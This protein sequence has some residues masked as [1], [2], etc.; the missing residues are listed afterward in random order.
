MKIKYTKEYE[1][2]VD[3]SKFKFTLGN[4]YD[5]IEYKISSQKMFIIKDDN[6]NQIKCPSNSK[7]I[8]H[9]KIIENDSN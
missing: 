6:G 3:N 2:F 8:K 4:I 9:F 7:I 5:L 1:P